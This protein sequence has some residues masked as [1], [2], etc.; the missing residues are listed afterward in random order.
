MINLNG[1]AKPVYRAFQ[2]LHG[3]GH[4]LLD[5]RGTHA[6]VDAWVITKEES[7]TVLMT[8]VAMPRHAIQTELVHLRLAGAAPPLPAWIE[9]IDAD[10]ANPRRL[11]HTMGEPEYLSAIEV[12]Q[13]KR[14]SALRKEPQPWT[15]DNGNIELMV[16]LQPQSVAAITFEFV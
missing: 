13:L 15:R 16:A 2:I 10:H 9:R 6:T 12:E 7:A 4:E 1:I 5:L 11:W 14:A 3:V 8:N